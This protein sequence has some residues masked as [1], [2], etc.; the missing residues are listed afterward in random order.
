MVLKSFK[1]LLK[2]EGAYADVDYHIVR[3]SAIKKLF[4]AFKNG[5]LSPVQIA[6]IYD[7]NFDEFVGNP[8]ISYLRSIGAAPMLE[9]LETKIQAG[10]PKVILPSQNCKFNLNPEKSYKKD[11]D[12]T[13]PS[14][15][16][17]VSADKKEVTRL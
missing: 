10:A 16:L 6:K 4:K 15:A 9:K 3:K 11:D 13:F 12:G 8:S 14:S 1:V 5:T 2:T 7:K 17:L